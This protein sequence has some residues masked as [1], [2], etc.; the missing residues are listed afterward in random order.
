VLTDVP[1]SRNGSTIWEAEWA[2]GRVG[3]TLILEAELFT[4]L[5]ISFL[6]K[7]A[8]NTACV[9]V[10]TTDPVKKQQYDLGGG[11]GGGARRANSYS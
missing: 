8:E 4:I 5:A 11:V 9:R 1:Q 6:W 3:L 10:L 2:T 7:T